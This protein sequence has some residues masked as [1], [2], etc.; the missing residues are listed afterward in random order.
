MRYVPAGIAQILVII[1]EAQRAFDGRIY[2]STTGLWEPATQA[3]QAAA[4]A[5]VDAAIGA[6]I[7]HTV[8]FPLVL[9]GIGSVTRA[10]VDGMVAS[11]RAAMRVYTVATT[12]A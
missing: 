11:L 5:M 9:D 3:T 4:D 1:E 2:N 7:T 12:K 8:T 6:V 10:Q